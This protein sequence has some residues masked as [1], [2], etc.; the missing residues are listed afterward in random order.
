MA[1][2]PKIFNEN[3][4]HRKVQLDRPTVHIALAYLLAEMLCM[5]TME[6]YV[7]ATFRALEGSYTV[8]AKQCTQ[9]SKQSIAYKAYKG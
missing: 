6:A 5:H 4:N 8:Q 9:L 2:K 3:F 1:L 7:V